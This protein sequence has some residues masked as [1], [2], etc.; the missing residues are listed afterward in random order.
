MIACE[1]NK[2]NRWKVCGIIRWKNLWEI[3]SNDIRDKERCFLQEGDRRQNCSEI[4]VKY[5]TEKAY[6]DILLKILFTS[7]RSELEV[8]LI[9]EIFDNWI[10]WVKTATLRMDIHEDNQTTESLQ[11]WLK[12]YIIKTKGIRLRC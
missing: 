6:T 12:I 8:N 1:Q 7:W 10:T 4:R 3:V 11:I 9:S 5:P 2:K